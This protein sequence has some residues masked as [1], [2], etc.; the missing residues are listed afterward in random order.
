MTI[1]I[2]KQLRIAG[3]D[4]ERWAEARQNLAPGGVD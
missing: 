4:I 2:A 3:E 1:D